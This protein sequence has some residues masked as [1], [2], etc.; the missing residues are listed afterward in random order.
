MQYT[1]RIMVCLLA[2]TGLAASCVGAIAQSVPAGYPDN[3]AD[4]IAA[5]KKEGKVTV[6]TSTDSAQAK[7]LLDAFRKAYPG[8]EIDWNDLGTNNSYNRTISEAAA[9]QVTA[10]IVWTSAMDL[11]VNLVE[12]GLTAPIDGPEAAAIPGWAKYKGNAFGT[13]VEP[14]AIIYKKN[15]FSEDAV[16]SSSVEL[17][18]IISD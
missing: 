5:A 18:K 3:Y 15:L 10:D 12:K 16:T 7:G 6:Y 4:V 11:Q 8:I 17:I 1:R 2:S 14:A 9:N 13:S